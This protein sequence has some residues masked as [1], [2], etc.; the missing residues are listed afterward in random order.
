MEVTTKAALIP[1]RYVQTVNFFFFEGI[2]VF[3]FR[4]TVEGLWFVSTKTGDIIYA[5]L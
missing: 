4:A 5:A 1:V 3:V 2:F